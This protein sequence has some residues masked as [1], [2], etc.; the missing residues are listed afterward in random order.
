MLKKFDQVVAL[1][2]DFTRNDAWAKE[3]MNKY[4]I[5]GMPTV[6]ILAPDGAERGRF[7]GYKSPGSF[8]EFFDKTLYIGRITNGI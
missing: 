4:N 3:M 8:M 7:T 1:K 6:I 5:T 2:M